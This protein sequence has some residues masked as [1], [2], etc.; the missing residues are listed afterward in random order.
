[1]GLASVLPQ[2]PTPLTSAGRSQLLAY[3]LHDATFAIGAQ[4]LLPAASS[5]L[6]IVTGKSVSQ[7]V[8]RI[9]EW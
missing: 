5:A 7:S 6:H 9:S 4:I 3:L 1:M 8:V 2:R